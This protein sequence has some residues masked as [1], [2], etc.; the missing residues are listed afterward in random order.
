LGVW[1]KSEITGP[2]P[3]G[4]TLTNCGHYHFYMV[5]PTVSAVCNAT[6]FVP[7]GTPPGNYSLEILSTCTMIDSTTV[8]DSETLTIQVP[9]PPG[10]SL[11]I[12]TGWG[13]AQGLSYGP[14]TVNITRVAGH[15]GDIF[16]SIGNPPNHVT[17]EFT[18]NPVTY[19]AT[20][21][22]M[23][24]TAENAAVPNTYSL[25]LLGNDGSIE[26]HKIFTM[27]VIEP[28]YLTLDPDT[29]TIPKGQYDVTE[30]NA[31]RIGLFAPDIDLVVEGTLIGGGPDFVEPGFSVNPL[32]APNSSFTL[33]LNVGNTVPIGEYILTLKGTGGTLEK[34]ATFVLNVTE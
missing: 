16:L 21:S 34:S 22:L 5:N 1:T 18:P 9:A 12:P 7:D 32:P 24:A 19:P 15:E 31:N 25:E 11:A 2:N 14:L 3:A 13:V 6:F 10:F 28:F 8:V 23:T 17:F 20:S 33:T 30:G 26:Q 29:I 27:L 4:I